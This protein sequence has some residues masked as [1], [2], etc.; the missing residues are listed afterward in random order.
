MFRAA[1]FVIAAISQTTVGVAQSRPNLTGTWTLDAAASRMV[2]AGGRVGPGPTQRTI[3]WIIEHREP[4]IEVTVN[5]RD[6][7]ESHDF[8]F[9]CTIDNR[10]CVNELRQLGEVRRIRAQWVGDTLEMTQVATTPHGT[11]AAVDRLFAIDGGR[12]L[13]FLRTVSDS[14]RGERR[15]IQVLRKEARL[16]SSRPRR[17][18]IIRSVREAA[19]LSLHDRSHPDRMMV[20]DPAPSWYHGCG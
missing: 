8:S 6:V 1:A 19:P 3:T 11:F 13:T 2:G 20:T 12:T 5:V 14:T 17:N 18:P 4:L 16:R 9:R 10:E 15:I 7:S